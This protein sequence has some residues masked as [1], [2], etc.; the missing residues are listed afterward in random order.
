MLAFFAR[1]IKRRCR[2]CGTRIEGEGVRHGQRVV[3]SPA[4]HQ[5]HVKERGGRQLKRLLVSRTLDDV[6]RSGRGGCC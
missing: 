5:A 6:M 4:H 2:R 3:C 1:A